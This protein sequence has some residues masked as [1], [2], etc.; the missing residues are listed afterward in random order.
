WPRKRATRRS[1]NANVRRALQNFR[2][3]P[4]PP[5]QSHL[6]RPIAAALSRSKISAATLTLRL[7]RSLPSWF[8]PLVWRSRFWLGRAQRR[9]EHLDQ[10]HR[11]VSAGGRALVRG[12]ARDDSQVTFI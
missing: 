9:S 1:S 6:R 7:R 5:R 11:E 12:A 10:D 3:S 8:S 4:R 2:H